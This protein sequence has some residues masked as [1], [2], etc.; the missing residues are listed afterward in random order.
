MPFTL[1]IVKSGSVVG[2]RIVLPM[3]TGLGKKEESCYSSGF[4]WATRFAARVS[5][6]TWKQSVC[7]TAGRPSLLPREPGAAGCPLLHSW[8]DHQAFGT[9]ANVN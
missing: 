6:G 5:L 2:A 8:E 7:V 4:S 1:R 3:V 9:S